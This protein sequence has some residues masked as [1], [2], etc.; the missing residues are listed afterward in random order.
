MNYL[1]QVKAGLCLA[2]LFGSLHLAWSLLIASGW[3]QIVTDFILRLHFIKLDY[4][5]E[6]FSIGNALL[7]IAITASIGYIVGWGFA[8]LWNSL[9]K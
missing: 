2:M 5:I 9:H 8:R 7:L 1:H 3:A 6:E 4:I